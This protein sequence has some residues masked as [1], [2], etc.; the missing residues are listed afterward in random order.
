[1]NELARGRL[2]REWRTIEAMLALYCR[3]VHQGSWGAL[4]SDCAELSAYAR[5]RLARC[6]FGADKPT[7][8]NCRVHCYR[9][10]MRERV[11]AM[12]RHAGPRLLLRHPVLTL[13]HLWIDDRRPA[14]AALPRRR[15]PGAVAPG[16]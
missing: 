14:P 16:A 2:R 10:A 15:P 11:R 5:E 4:C 1:V 13:L 9:P 8:A 3:Q 6:P 7:C 12:M